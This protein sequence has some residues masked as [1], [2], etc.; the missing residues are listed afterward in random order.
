MNKGVLIKRDKQRK[1]DAKMLAVHVFQGRKNISLQ[2]PTQD[3]L[4]FLKFGTFLL[5]PSN[6]KK[7]K[8]PGLRVYQLTE[9][10][11]DL[12]LKKNKIKKE[13]KIN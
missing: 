5:L 13:W 3:L 12:K 9:F 7:S 10:D 1:R 6:F 4:L 11:F 2:T 8:T